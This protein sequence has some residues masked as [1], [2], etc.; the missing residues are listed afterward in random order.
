MSLPVPTDKRLPPISMWQIDVANEASPRE[1][2]CRIQ[3]QV[4][5]HG[6]PPGKLT[7]PAASPPGKRRAS[8]PSRSGVCGTKWHSQR[9]FDVPTASSGFIELETEELELS[10]TSSKP[11]GAAFQQD[12]RI[13]SA[14]NAM[15][16]GQA[17]VR[18]S[19]K[20]AHWL[21]KLFV[22]AKLR[23]G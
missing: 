15:Q 10:S 21:R 12:W 7:L 3:P 2:P 11:C 23:R 6:T 1:L 8:R 20:T 19:F 22:K 5:R 14:A 17:P 4:A 18:N 13:Q 9:D 16:G